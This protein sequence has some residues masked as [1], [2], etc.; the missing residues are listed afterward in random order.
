[1]QFT[2]YGGLKW[3]DAWAGSPH[4]GS[5]ECSVFRSLSLIEDDF[6]FPDLFTHWVNHLGDLVRSVSHME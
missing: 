3:V 1:M 4:H 2:P 5:G 6:A